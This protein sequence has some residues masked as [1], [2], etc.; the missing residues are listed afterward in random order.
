MNIV[1]PMLRRCWRCGFRPTLLV[2]V[3]WLPI[4]R[5]GEEMDV[6][7]RPHILARLGCE[8]CQD[9]RSTS[10]RESAGLIPSP[11]VVAAL[12]MEWNAA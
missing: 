7:A 11:D 2:R 4:V 6:L 10:E 8:K 3:S 5:I 9:P 1:V 12:A